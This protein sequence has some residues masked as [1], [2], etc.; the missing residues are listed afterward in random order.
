MW[1]EILT[2]FEIITTKIQLDLKIDFWQLRE[3]SLITIKNNF[4]DIPILRGYFSISRS[5]WLSDI[6]QY[7][8][9]I[10]PIIKIVYVHEINK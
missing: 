5:N 4:T 1:S 9:A 7:W 8:L 3:W 2:E 6:F 10:V